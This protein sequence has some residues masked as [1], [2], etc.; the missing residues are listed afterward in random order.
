MIRLFD[1]LDN[2]IL[3][4]YMYRFTETGDFYYMAGDVLGNDMF[5]MLGSVRVFP[6][7][8]TQANLHL[9][10]NGFNSTRSGKLN[11]LKY[12]SCRYSLVCYPSLFT[13]SCGLLPRFPELKSLTF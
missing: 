12:T 13:L 6:Q 4:Q 5:Q 2:Y 11:K 1:F 9:L 7:E 10:L 8:N 3:G